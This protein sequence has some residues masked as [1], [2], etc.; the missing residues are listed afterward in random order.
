MEAAELITALRCGRKY[1]QP[2]REVSLAGMNKSTATA[3]GM[4]ME[5]PI[6]QFLTFASCE[7]SGVELFFA[8]K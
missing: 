2:P 4:A 1:T 6:I 5:M 8:M 3:K 7:A